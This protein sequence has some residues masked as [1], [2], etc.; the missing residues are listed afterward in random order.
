MDKNITVNLTTPSSK[1]IWNLAILTT[2]KSPSSLVWLLQQPPII[3][4][5]LTPEYSPRV[6]LLEY[7]LDQV[8]VCS[9]SSKHFDLSLRIQAHRATCSQFSLPC[10]PHLQH[11]Y[12]CHSS[13]D[14]VASRS[15]LGNNKHTPRWGYL[16][17]PFPLTGSFPQICVTCSLTFSRFLSNCHMSKAP[18]PTFKSRSENSP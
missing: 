5:L 13:S 3:G 9:K 11:S 4:L 1:Y 16:R 14:P 7:D 8:L 15:F 2:S 10:S 17:R 12:T 6:I 18:C